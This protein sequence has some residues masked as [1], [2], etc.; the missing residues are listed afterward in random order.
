MP[1]S[2]TDGAYLVPSTATAPCARC[3]VAK[4][5]NNAPLQSMRCEVVMSMTRA[6]E[7]KTCIRRMLTA[8]T[9]ARPCNVGTARR[10]EVHG[11][12]NARIHH[13]LPNPSRCQHHDG[14]GHRNLCGPQRAYEVDMPTHASEIVKSSRLPRTYSDAKFLRLNM[15]PDATAD[16]PPSARMCVR[17]RRM[18]TEGKAS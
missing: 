16:G 5:G 9:A 6:A 11:F 17:S 18:T 2:A 15:W 1:K 13:E 7:S 8:L 4:V 3:V 12:A 14:A 10:A